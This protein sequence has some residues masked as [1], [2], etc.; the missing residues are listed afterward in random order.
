MLKTIRSKVRTPCKTNTLR[1]ERKKMKNSFRNNFVAPAV[2]LAMNAVNVAVRVIACLILNA[3]LTTR[4][5]DQ[6]A[7]NRNT[8]IVSSSAVSK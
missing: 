7:V 4:E 8:S 5:P 2:N 3:L 6:Y 1:V